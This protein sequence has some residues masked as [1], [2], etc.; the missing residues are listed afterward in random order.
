[1]KAATR[2]VTKAYNAHLQ[3]QHI[4]AAYEISKL[5]GR[6]QQYTLQ[7]SESILGQPIRVLGCGSTTVEIIASDQGNRT[8]PSYVAFTD[9]ERLIGDAAKNQD[10]MNPMNTVFG[11]VVSLPPMSSTQ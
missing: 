9:T 5:R 8:T 7:Q 1:M 10:A 11:V 2:F 3:Q 4:V 6:W